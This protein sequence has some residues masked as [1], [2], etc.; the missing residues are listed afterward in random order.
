MNE[1]GMVF[2]LYRLCGAYPN[3]GSLLHWA[4]LVLGERWSRIGIGLGRLSGDASYLRVCWI[5]F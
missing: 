3:Y 4:C 5:A 2:P 1:P